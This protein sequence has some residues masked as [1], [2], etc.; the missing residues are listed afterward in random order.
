[1]T[2]RSGGRETFFLHFQLYL[3][4]K[5]SIIIFFIKKKLLIHFSLAL[6]VS[7]CVCLCVIVLSFVL[8]ISCTTIFLQLLFI[9]FIGKKR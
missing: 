9:V 6:S 8:K 2:Y 5:I 7:I 4:N 1:M 3:E